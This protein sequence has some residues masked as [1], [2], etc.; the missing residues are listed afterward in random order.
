M[1]AYKK[2]DMEQWSRRQ[3]YRY[4]T[5]KLKIGYSVTTFLDITRILSYCHEKK[6]KFYPTII[7]CVTKVLNEI[8]NFRM[9]RNA[10]GELCIWDYIIPSYTIFHKDDKTFS[11][12]WTEYSK[13]YG[14]FYRMIT[15]DM[16]Y[17]KDKKGI[18]VKPEQPANFYCISCVPWFSFTGY[19][20]YVA[21]GEPQF[22]PIITIGK[23]EKSGNTVT[24]P[25]NLS[26]A[27]A[28]ADGYHTGLFFEK[29]QKELKEFNG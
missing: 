26:I 29:L 5:E 9:F 24:M 19:N 22:F 12:C 15:E 23:Y 2:V 13:G 17:Y 4:Y 16:D 18:K 20:S 3:H 27:H 8:E 11:D 1:A 25:L 28:V 10:Q 14:S 21:E 7:Y 6:V